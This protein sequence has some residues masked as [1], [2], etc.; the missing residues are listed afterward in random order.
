M[1]KI[2]FLNN[3]YRHPKDGDTQHSQ[4]NGEGLQPQRTQPRTLPL[5]IIT[6]LSPY[7]GWR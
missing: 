7:K 2:L 1:N 3:L 4:G 5:S 6:T